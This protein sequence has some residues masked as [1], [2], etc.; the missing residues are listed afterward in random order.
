M[1]YLLV[2]A[3]PDDEA[4][5]AG[6]S[7][8]KFTKNGDKADICVMSGSADARA[9][10]PGDDELESDMFSC[11]RTLGIERSFIGD[12]PNIKLNTVAHLDL[13]KHIENAIRQSQ[14]DIVITHHPADVNNDH[15]HTSLA[16]Q[17]AVRLFQRQPDVPALRELWFMEVPSS[18]E[19]CVNTSMNKFE[20]DTFVEIGKDGL[21]KKIEALS[22]YR[23]VERAYPHPR[24]RQAIEGLAAF[25]GAQSGCD[26]A[27]AFQVVFRR[28]TF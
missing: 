4:L 15:L 20:P 22:R 5:G 19:W 10:R 7:I 9:F 6:A 2:V 13:V 8:Y 16:C 25:R 3:H 1:K 17:A 26:Y 27:E 21:E 28:I 18:T 23:G 14:P 11:F 12:F 24:S